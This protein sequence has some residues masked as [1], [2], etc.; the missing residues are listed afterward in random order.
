MGGGGLGMFL[1]SAF[2][3]WQAAQIRNSRQS[4]TRPERGRMLGRRRAGGQ[5][6]E[7]QRQRSPAPD[8]S[9]MGLRQ[10]EHDPFYV[11]LFFS[12]TDK[13]PIHLTTA[14]GRCTLLDSSA[15]IL[16]TVLLYLIYQI[17]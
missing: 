4:A 12:F 7:A 15:T 6:A 10:L 2:L 13:A 8:R 1:L 11:P 9:Q 14:I 5:I 3:V 17:G 16:D